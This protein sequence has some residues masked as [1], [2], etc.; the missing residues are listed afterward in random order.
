MNYQKE[1]SIVFLYT[2]NELSERELSIP[3][4]IISKRIKYLGIPAVKQ[5][6]K[7]PTAAAPVTVV[8]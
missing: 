1:K 3:S 8:V 5:W 7:N 4:T 6:V 2:N